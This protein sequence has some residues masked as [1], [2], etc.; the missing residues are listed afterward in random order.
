M[1]ESEREVG[2][3]KVRECERGEREMGEG[4]MGERGV[5]ERWV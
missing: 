3:K 4:E 5:R 1:R 2:V